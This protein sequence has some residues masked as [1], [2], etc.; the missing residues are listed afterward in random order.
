MAS[1]TNCGQV[2]WVLLKLNWPTPCPGFLYPPEVPL[3]FTGDFRNIFWIHINNI[4]LGYNI[5]TESY[6]LPLHFQ[7]AFLRVA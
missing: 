1:E 5:S 4:P 3:E 2:T 7:L 6:S